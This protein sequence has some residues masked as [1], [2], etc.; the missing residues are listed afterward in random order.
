MKL[1]RLLI[2]LPFLFWVTSCTTTDVTPEERVFLITVEDLKNHGVA[3]G[4][5]SAA[6]EKYAAR[7]FI[8][9]TTEIE[10]EYDAEKDPANSTVI[11][12]FS[13]ADFLRNETLAITAYDDAIEAY[14]F[15]AT[16][17]NNDVEFVEVPEAFTLGE[18]NYTAILKTNGVPFG[19]LIVTRKGNMVYSFILAG[20]YINSKNT[21]NSLIGPKLAF[22]NE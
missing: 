15:G 17:N 21:L 16:L 8:N 9:G 19:N 1:S 7:R 11:L 2:F 14:H 6:G 3:V 13:E 22:F 18:Q 10:Y 4:S 20:P 5:A 12:F